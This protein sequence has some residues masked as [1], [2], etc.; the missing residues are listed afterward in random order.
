MGEKSFR[1]SISLGSYI[2]YQVKNRI[3]TPRTNVY[4]NSLTVTVYYTVYRTQY[5]FSSAWPV[6]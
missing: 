3:Y 1:I 5:A 2:M 6:S 4:I